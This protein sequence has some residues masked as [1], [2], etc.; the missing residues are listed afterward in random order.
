[1]Y[2]KVRNEPSTALFAREDIQDI[3]PLRRNKLRLY[4]EMTGGPSSEPNRETTSR[5]LHAARFGMTKESASRDGGRLHNQEFLFRR[6]RW[7]SAFSGQLVQ[8]GAGLFVA[9]IQ[10]ERALVEEDR[11]FRLTR[12]FV[13]SAQEFGRV[14][15]AVTAA[16]IPVKYGNRLG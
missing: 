2:P 16:E 13:D 5:F 8:P 10:R 9:G 3:R 6:L 12:R 15:A 11:L 14:G 4:V 7:R 1:M